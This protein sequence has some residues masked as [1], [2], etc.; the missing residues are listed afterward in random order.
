MLNMPDNS[1][2][3]RSRRTTRRKRKKEAPSIL[4]TP[5]RT[6]RPKDD[7]VASKADAIRKEFD[8]WHHH[9]MRGF[10]LL[11][12]G[13]GSKRTAM[14]EFSFFWPDCSPPDHPDERV[15]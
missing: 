12:Y 4:D 1:F 14:E 3:T 6:G 8:Q 15:T 7:E 10:N 11:L 13:Y 2:F 5:A 9:Q